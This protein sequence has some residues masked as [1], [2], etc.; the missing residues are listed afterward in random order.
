MYLVP[1][2]HQ[3]RGCG[4]FTLH[5][6]QVFLADGG[7]SFWKTEEAKPSLAVLEKEYCGEN[8]IVLESLDLSGDFAFARVNAN[9]TRLGDFY[10]WMETKDECWRTFY[11]FVSDK[12]QIIAKESLESL[13]L[14]T[15]S[16]ALVCSEV[17]RLVS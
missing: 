12:G 11:F 17:L 6:L 2:I 8:G 13:Y 16:A 7:N 10:K 3:K 4:S 5:A 1:Y 15:H 9:Q 14:G